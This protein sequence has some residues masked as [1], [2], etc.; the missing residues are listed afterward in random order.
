[1]PELK[2]IP[3]N[4]IRGNPVALRDVNKNSDKFAELV[5][6]VKKDGIINPINVRRKAGED[7]KE[8]ELIDGLQRFSASQEVGTGVVDKGQGVFEDTVDAEG[9]P[10]K[11]GVI[12]AQVIEREDAEALTSQIIA[13]AHRIETK[14]VEYST[15]IRRYLGTNPTLTE[16]GL[17]GILN[18]SPQWISKILGLQKLGDSVKP[19]VDEGKMS[20]SNAFALSNLPGEEQMNWLERAQ[21]MEAGLFTQAALARAK[22]IKDANRKGKDAGPEQFIPVTHLRKKPEVEAEMN[23][24]TVVAALIRDQNITNEIKTNRE[25]LVQAAIVGAQ[26]ALKWALNFDPASIE[27]AKAK[28]DKRRQT[29]AEAKIRRDAERTTKK[30]QEA[31][32]RADEAREAAAKAR[33]AAAALPPV[34][35]EA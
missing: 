17:A 35:V 9:K 8:Y 12:P 34:P 27:I 21:T 15:A 14:P 32:K 23:T 11:I 3:L 20:L 24:P 26:M 25:G 2:Y 30:E 22:E 7:G 28:D 4:R 33:E 31:A 13:N 10:S 19:L 16:A 6:S 1:M 5:G 29:E 18:K